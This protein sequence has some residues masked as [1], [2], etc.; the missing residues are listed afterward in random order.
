MSSVHFVAE[1]RL[2]FLAEVAYYQN[3][4]TNLGLDFSAAV[5]AA[6]ARIC[7]FPLSGSPAVAGTRRV[8]LYSFPFA[9]FYL[10]DG[11]S[12]FVLAV[13]HTSRK[14]NYWASRVKNDQAVV[15]VDA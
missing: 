6:A 7:A 12:V 4:Q 5:E 8:L 15:R 3:I 11:S 9:L 1:A 2:E 14:P 10:Y 13:A